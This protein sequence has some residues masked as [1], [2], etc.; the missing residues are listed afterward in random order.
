MNNDQRSIRAAVEARLAR[1]HRAEKR[2]RL[3][4]LGAIGLA[5]TFLALL[6]TSIVAQS[7]TAFSA[8]R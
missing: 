6:I 7:V 4:G 8:H 1:R 3:Y 2:F 5:V